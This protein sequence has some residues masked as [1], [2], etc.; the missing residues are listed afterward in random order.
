MLKGRH[1]RKCSTVSGLSK[2]QD[3]LK[4]AAYSFNCLLIYRNDYGIGNPGNFV[5]MIL[6]SHDLA[7]A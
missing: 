1:S 7:R 3:L 2:E 6:H 5:T 4:D